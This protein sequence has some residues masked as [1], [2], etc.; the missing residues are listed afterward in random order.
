MIHPKQ[1]DMGWMWSTLRLPARRLARPVALRSVLL[2]L[3]VLL[4]ELTGC[5]GRA[6]DRSAPPASR[7]P[8]LETATRL[9]FPLVDRPEPSPSFAYA[10]ADAAAPL[11]DARAD[12]RKGPNRCESWSS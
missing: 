8:G 12:A 7:S 2:I 9:V 6:H 10:Q 4:V 1:G 11:T 3:L 5:S